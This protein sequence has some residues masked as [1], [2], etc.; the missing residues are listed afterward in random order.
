MNSKHRLK[1]RAACDTAKNSEISLKLSSLLFSLALS[2]PFLLL[3]SL[4]QIRLV[5]KELS[6]SMS[7]STTNSFISKGQGEFGSSYERFNIWQSDQIRSQKDVKTLEMEGC[8]G[9]KCQSC[10]CPCILKQIILY[11]K[12]KQHGIKTCSYP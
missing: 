10:G 4:H 9:V 3:I 5:E 11:R 8:V 6:C 2:I 12:Q 1:F 7:Y